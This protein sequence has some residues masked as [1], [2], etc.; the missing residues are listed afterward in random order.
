M[1]AGVAAVIAADS[2]APPSAA[3]V[4][5]DRT[6]S[7]LWRHVALVAVCAIGLVL[8]SRG[9]TDERAVSMDG[10]MPHY[11]MNG[12]F[13]YDLMRDV[14]LAAPFTYA[15][16][17]YARYPALTL[18]HHPFVPPLVEVPFFALFGVSVF[19]ARLAVV[20]AFALLLVFWFKLI[21]NLY[22]TNTAFIASLFLVST[23]GIVPLFQVVLSEPFTLCLIVLSLYAMHQYGVTGRGRYAIA[24]AVAA[25]LSAYTKHLAVFMFPVYLFQF[26]AAFG[27]RALFQRSTVAIG[28]AI[29]VCILPLVPLTLKYSHWNM[30]I[31]TQ[32]VDT[33]DRTSTDS[34]MRFARWIWSGQFR[35]SVPVTLLAGAGAA[36]AAV[37]RD[38]RVLVLVAWVASVYAGL[39]VVGV[40]NDRFFCYWVPAFCGL[41][42]ATLQVWP[43]GRLRAAWAIVLIAVA[44]FQFR[45]NASDRDTPTTAAVRPV[46]AAGYEEAAKYV[47][48][49][50]IGETV[51]YSAAV[52]TGYFVFFARKADPAQTM[53]VM[54]ADKTLT[55]SRMRIS[56]FER[57]IARRDEILPI[58]QQY[59]VGHVVIEDR[60]YPDGPLRWLQE[61]VE[62]P[63][64]TLR[65]RIPIESNDLRLSGA[66]LSVY[67]FNERVPAARDAA[68]SIGV[69]LM[70][71]SIQVPLSDLTRR[72]AAR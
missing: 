32:F 3:P 58:L 64:F 43:A 29:A 61:I 27:V 40:A 68:L 57:K 20:C 42:A 48:A 8:V 45:A 22:D 12:V 44:V 19:S 21:R 5:V 4:I 14:P 36:A 62:T 2:N 72:Q 25:T 50:R 54:R 56:D 39:L 53:V 51:L 49:N 41:A 31:V 38:R 6:T 23:P 33:G 46:G 67:E 69:P 10:D 16:R 65:R 71:G 66:T 1:S 30:T 63:S 18:G 47:T 70:N 26:V 17:Y 34:L 60:P 13:L 24:F 35:L 55:T 15:Q 7:R 59:G 37:R 11:L 52:D 9:L 28:T